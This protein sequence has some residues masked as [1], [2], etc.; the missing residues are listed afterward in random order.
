MRSTFLP[1][2]EGSDKTDGPGRPSETHQSSWHHA[3]RIKRQSQLDWQR[4]KSVRQRRLILIIIADNLCGNGEEL[5][6]YSRAGVHRQC[7][8]HLLA[9]VE[10]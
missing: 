9:D 7:E 1:T 8:I 2:Q 4:I 6:N 10:C 5:V 3:L